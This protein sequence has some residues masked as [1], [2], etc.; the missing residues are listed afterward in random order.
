MDQELSHCYR[1]KLYT[2]SFIADGNEKL[3]KAICD[4]GNAVD[5]NE[6]IIPESKNEIIGILNSIIGGYP[7]TIKVSSIFDNFSKMVKSR[8]SGIAMI[9]PLWQ[10]VEVN[11]KN[12][13]A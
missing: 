13:N 3:A 9:E 2:E 7:S 11:I 8:I 5:A 6:S 12:R 4:F 1:C 10:V